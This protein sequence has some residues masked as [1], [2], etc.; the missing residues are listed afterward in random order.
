MTDVG[1][2]VCGRT[3]DAL[4]IWVRQCFERLGDAERSFHAK[5]CRDV[6]AEGHVLTWE[7]HDRVARAGAGAQRG[8]R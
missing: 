5:F 6:A 1:G 4:R 8:G 2:E 3:L 7:V